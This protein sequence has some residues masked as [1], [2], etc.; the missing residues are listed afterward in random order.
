MDGIRLDAAHHRALVHGL[1]R[2]RGRELSVKVLELNATNKARCT[3]STR[4][5]YVFGAGHTDGFQ[6]I[7]LDATRF[8]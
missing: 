8:M 7:S 6:C 1:L 4:H 2:S 5:V 3:F